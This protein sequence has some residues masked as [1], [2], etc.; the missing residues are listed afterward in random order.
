MNSFIVLSLPLPPSCQTPSSLDPAKVWGLFKGDSW[1]CYGRVL[2]SS[3]PPS[4]SPHWLG[5]LGA[6]GHPWGSL[7]PPVTPGGL[8]HH[9]CAG[10]MGVCVCMLVCVRACVCVRVRAHVRMCAHF[11][12]WDRA[13][14]EPG[15]GRV[16][17]GGAPNG[18]EPPPSQGLPCL[19]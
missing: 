15:P 5:V 18:S 14:E 6:H 16:A 2:V 12:A 1:S 3:H 13:F 19:Y 9:Q 4:L 10:Q 11:C 8:G 17:E 7:P